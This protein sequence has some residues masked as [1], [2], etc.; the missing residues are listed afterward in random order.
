M[1]SRRPG[2]SGGDVMIVG[3]RAAMALALVVLVA[4]GIF[5]TLAS[6]D[7]S[8]SGRV[9]SK[10]LKEYARLR[11]Y[12]LNRAEE[13]REEGRVEEA[14]AI[15]SAVQ[16][17]DSLIQEAREAYQSG[18]LSLAGQKVREAFNTIM[19]ALRGVG[20]APGVPI[21]RRVAAGIERNRRLLGR[22]STAV[23]RLERLGVDV[24]DLREALATASS[25]LDEAQSLLEEGRP[26]A[27]AQKLTEAHRVLVRVVERIREIVRQA[28]NVNV[29][30]RAE[31]IV[32]L[33][34]RT[35]SRLEE[36]EQRLI[37][38]NRTDAAARVAQVRARLGELLSQFES[39]VQA[40]DEE[41]AR[42]T[43]RE[44][45]LILRGIARHLRSRR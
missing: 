37:Q 38:A 22:L 43:L 39:Q 15:E 42:Q 30:E 31:K 6:A 10:I 44:M 8:A 24:T 12:A 14:Q 5:M 1:S 7:P 40:G 2:E 17:A 21:A 33:V 36:V 9:I 25:L 20:E 29:T 23:D 32:E 27:A 4:G 13:L 19:E 34:E 16:E 35:I 45:M 3:T 28:G 26:V 18:N 41:A 11:S